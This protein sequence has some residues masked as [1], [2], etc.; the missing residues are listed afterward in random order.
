[1][2]TA[3]AST[4][5][6]QAFWDNMRV[7]LRANLDEYVLKRHL[8]SGTDG[9]VLDHYKSLHVGDPQWPADE[10]DVPQ[11]IGDHH[12]FWLLW[13]DEARNVFSFPPGLVDPDNPITFGK[14]FT[15]DTKDGK[16]PRYKQLVVNGIGYALASGGGSVGLGVRL[17]TG[18][19]LRDT[20]RDTR[21][22]VAFEDI[23][24]C[25]Y[26]FI[27]IPI[28]RDTP[29]MEAQLGAT[30]KPFVYF[31]LL[32]P[33]RGAWHPDNIRC[34]ESNGNAHAN[35]T[36]LYDK[37]RQF[38]GDKVKPM[39]E[40]A[41]EMLQLR[42]AQAKTAH[43]AKLGNGTLTGKEF[44]HEVLSTFITPKEDN[45]LRD[46]LGF[47]TASLHEI[48]TSAS[49]DGTEVLKKDNLTSLYL[50]SIESMCADDEGPK[51]VCAHIRGTLQTVIPLGD[52]N[53]HLILATAE[54]DIL[55]QDVSAIVNPLLSR[56]ATLVARKPAWP[57]KTTDRLGEA[58]EQLKWHELVTQKV[59]QAIVKSLVG[60]DEPDSDL[61]LLEMMSKARAE[62][63][64]TPPPISPA[65]AIGGKILLAAVHGQEDWL[66]TDIKA[67]ADDKVCKRAQYEFNM[68]PHT[69]ATVFRLLS[70]LHKAD[71]SLL[72]TE[73]QTLSVETPS[74]PP[75]KS[76]VTLPDQASMLDCGARTAVNDSRIWAAWGLD[77][78]APDSIDITGISS[79]K[80]QITIG[81]LSFTVFRNRET[82]ACQTLGFALSE[83]AEQAIR[84]DLE[85]LPE[86]LPAADFI[87]D[88]P[89]VL[90][91]VFEKCDCGRNEGDKLGCLPCISQ[92]A[93]NWHVTPTGTGCGEDAK[94]DFATED[95]KEHMKTIV[96][97]G[98]TEAI[99]VG[100]NSYVFSPLWINSSDNE[101]VTHGFLVLGAPQREY[102]TPD[103]IYYSKYQLAAVQFA[104][105]YLELAISRE[106]EA[107]KAVEEKASADRVRHLAGIEPEVRSLIDDVN[108]MKLTAER[109]ARRIAPAQHGVFAYDSETV[110]LFRA[111]TLTVDFD[112]PGG[113]K[114]EKLTVWQDF[115]E[116]EKGDPGAD[117]LPSTSQERIETVRQHSTGLHKW[118]PTLILKLREGSWGTNTSWL[119]EAVHDFD[120]G[121]PAEVWNR[122]RDMLFLLGLARANGLMR[123][124]GHYEAA[125][126][127]YTRLFNAAKLIF[128]RLHFPGDNRQHVFAVQLLSALAGA[129]R[130]TTVSG[131]VNFE[132]KNH[133][134]LVRGIASA[135]E[136]L[137][138]EKAN[139]SL[140]WRIAGNANEFVPQLQQFCLEFTNVTKD[141]D[142]ELMNIRVT[143]N[144]PEC[145]ITLT[146]DG[147]FDAKL[148][149]SEVAGEAIG[150]ASEH[151]LTCSVLVLEKCLRAY[152][153]K[154]S[155][156]AFSYA[157]DRGNDGSSG[158]TV[159]TL[160]LKG[161]N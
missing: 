92:I 64:E 125:S 75:L 128:H 12:G 57:A 14:G 32:Y 135:K 104:G 98:H 144:Q 110:K 16:W 123:E 117:Y 157:I 115:L 7:Y 86:S 47:R 82:P 91:T 97:V 53:A 84:K 71:P 46:L 141:S 139:E 160:R 3:S 60:Q 158:Q 2:N 109:V 11:W 136:L 34:C 55:A 56:H 151:S 44:R 20:I 134:S 49:R 45:A 37:V 83:E 88:S 24:S 106:I 4:A 116:L 39:V 35:C 40:L 111:N 131:R 21:G 27:G 108:R 120:S 23:L 15:P 26:S 148:H 66:I 81:P 63:V 52:L 77:G 89:S 67:E 70:A 101:P 133:R 129:S 149:R 155:T 28:Y 154:D 69:K 161:D 145:V 96:E 99:K 103:R 153:K 93:G 140:K 90:R 105:D 36:C 62:E 72:P 51:A 8:D 18:V 6:L 43:V 122:Y 41:Y 79:D 127:E 152:L 78:T 142:V 25:N 124:F 50:S 146:C 147:V 87:K 76:E 113:D 121:V 138:A 48:D 13:H 132:F 59:C 73:G 1:M 17:D 102:D 95:N 19:C 54:G 68:F 74:S 61:H 159:F 85:H 143:M 156:D 65:V 42:D 118:E 33:A 107:G 119:F 10:T 114:D 112:I 31:C 9:A 38:C 94:C 150:V 126:G 137:S 100:V 29:R 80:W 130:A 58:I 5:V 30:G 22:A